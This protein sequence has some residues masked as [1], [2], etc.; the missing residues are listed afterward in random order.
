M[1]DLKREE[2]EKE[3]KEV[4]SKTL[5]AYRA[6]LCK[7]GKDSPPGQMQSHRHMGWAPGH[8]VMPRKR[9]PFLPLTQLPV[10]AQ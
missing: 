2:S 10:G 4:Q 7:M 1:G 9:W 6:L 5:L 8:A 3:K